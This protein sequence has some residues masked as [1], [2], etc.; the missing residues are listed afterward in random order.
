MANSAGAVLEELATQG[1][2]DF[3]GSNNG[4]SVL[5]NSNFRNWER[6]VASVVLDRGIYGSGKYREKPDSDILEG[7]LG[8]IQK[9]QKPLNAP[10]IITL[11]HPFYAIFSHLNEIRPRKVYADFFREYGQLI[12][13]LLINRPFGDK[14]NLVIFETL[15]HYAAATSRLLEEGLIDAVF[16][17]EWD[18]GYLLESKDLDPLK[19]RT[20][21]SGGAYYN[22]C[23]WASLT[24]LNKAVTDKSKLHVVKELVAKSPQDGHFS[25]SVS[26]EDLV[27]RSPDSKNR[28]VSVA[29][30]YGLLS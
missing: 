16:L 24:E 13:N 25:L 7:A 14:A 22:K 10:N 19:D 3:F 30:M 12:R 5:L 29:E 23:L 1:W 8:H 6:H 26:D 27:S 11:T 17:T 2:N 4:S 28:V 15:H 21:F 20:F 18:T 9:Y